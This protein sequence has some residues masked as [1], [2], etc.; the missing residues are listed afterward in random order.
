MIR[1]DPGVVDAFVTTLAMPELDVVAVWFTP[2]SLKV[3][4]FPAIAA[5]LD[6]FNFAERVTL[7]P[8][9]V[10]VGPV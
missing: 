3:T 6:V 10:E 8:G 4:V 5:P 2:L 1:Y 7:P 9:V